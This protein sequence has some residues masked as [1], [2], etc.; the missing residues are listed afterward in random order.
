MKTLQI[1]RYLEDMAFSEI[2]SRQMRFIIGPRQTGKTT[3]AK[4]KLTISKCEKFYYNW[5]RK[6]IRNRYRNEIDF[7]AKDFLENPILSKP[8]ICFDEIHKMPKWKNILKNFFDTHEGKVNIIVTGS[9][10]LDMFRRAGDSL[11]GRYFLF[12]LNPL[13]FPEILSRKIDDILPESTA[14]KFIEK[15]IAKKTYEQKILEDMLNFSSFP[16][17]FLRGNSLFSKKWH[18]TYLEKIV[19]EDLRDISSIHQLERVID[20]LYLLPSKIS[21]TLSINSL[22]EDIE[23]NFNT[24]KNY[25]N[26][27]ILTYVLFDVP[28]Y[29]KKI[30]RLVKK[31]KK[32]YFYDFT[33]IQDESAKF[34]NFLALELKSNIDLW[35]DWTK[36][37]YELT[38]VKTRDG[39]ETDFLILKNSVPWLLCEAKLSETQIKSHHFLHSKHLGDIPFVQ[40]VKKSDVLKVEQ[41]NFFV[42][43][44]SRFLS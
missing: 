38:F 20:L 24:I 3:L 28:P 29:Q 42:V 14:N 13:M 43:S 10:R 2:F 8:W 34:E 5:D 15:S 35:N 40:L 4:H 44:A 32:I 41:K 36:D 21:S 27:L 31:E 26:Y 16:E 7:V 30:S 23:L 11:A 6:E 33:M 22:R 37:K 39:R 17:P 12:K 9:A 19:Q 18:E 1:K 25:L